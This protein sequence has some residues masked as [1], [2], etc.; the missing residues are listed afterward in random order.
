MLCSNHR[1]SVNESSR[2]YKRL[3]MKKTLSCSLLFIL[4]SL[5]GFSQ[6]FSLFEKKEFIQNGDTLPYRILLPLN[7]DANTKYPMI[8]FLHGA[9]ERGNDNEKQLVHGAKLFLEDSVR[10]KY[11]AII[12]FPQCPQNSFWANIDMRVDSITKKRMFLYKE[13]GA[14]SKAMELLIG[15]YQDLTDK[16]A[17]DAKRM[18][19]GGLSMG[20]MGT[21]EITRRLP[22]NFAAAFAICGGA[23]TATAD[24]LKNTAWWV[25]HGMK[26]NVVNP[27][28]S[29]D[30]AKAL[31]E[32]GAEVKLTLYP[33][34]DHNSWDAAFKEPEFFSWLFGHRLE[35]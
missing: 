20:G 31:K 14:P 12:V 22:N 15:L 7:Y 21:F 1:L 3:Q 34:A 24:Q 19:V 30:M 26:D 23:N 9:G 6:D 33:E 28:N 2:L 5:Q 32:A 8:L 10:N 16:Y 17:T 11:P 18:Y 35:K 4:I 25:F 27:Q 13:N 29:I